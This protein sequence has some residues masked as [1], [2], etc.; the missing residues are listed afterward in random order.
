MKAGHLA[1]FLS[2]C[3]GSVLFPLGLFLVFF[4]LLTGDLTTGPCSAGYQ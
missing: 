3:I 1:L 2:L 4:I